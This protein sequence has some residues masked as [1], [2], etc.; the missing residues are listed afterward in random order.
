MKK[1]HNFS[2]QWAHYRLTLLATVCAFIATSMIGGSFI[3]AK[4]LNE[5]RLSLDAFDRES[6]IIWQIFQRIGSP[7]DIGKPN[8]RRN[9]RDNSPPPRESIGIIKLS[10]SWTIVSIDIPERL[11]SSNLEGIITVLQDEVRTWVYFH[12]WDSTGIKEREWYFFRIFMGWNDSLVV[13]SRS[14]YDKD[15]LIGDILYFLLVNFVFILPF[16]LVSSSLIRRILRPIRKNI[17]EMEAFI[18]DA[19]HEL[20]T[21]LAIANGNLQLLSKTQ[22]G[23]EEI[24]QAQKA[25]K[26][27][28]N[29]I[30]TLVE[31][32]SLE[33]G[34]KNISCN[35]GDVLSEQ[36]KVLAE[37]IKEK[38]IKVNVKTLW[39]VNLMIAPEHAIILIHNLLENAIK[40]NTIWWSIS[41]ELTEKSLIVHDTWIGMAKEHQTKIFDRF[42]R[43]NRSQQNG[44]G[45]GL[46]LIAK[47]C[48]IYHMKIT[49]KSGEWLWSTFK[50]TF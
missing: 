50:I 22:K 9:F 6:Q 43:I 42:Y 17:D 4:Y 21:P 41:I 15:D 10:S 13:L 32:S 30:T 31:L 38:S 19:G 33:K 37:S 46:A 39:D 40:Y 24:H 35:M 16:A 20:K 18:H 45:I 23:N 8:M 25:I 47:I 5:Y 29:L 49:V 26:H 27:A 36:M 12:G 1:E 11:L 2:L 44:H 48:S 34:P 28:D 3:W 14:A 7:R